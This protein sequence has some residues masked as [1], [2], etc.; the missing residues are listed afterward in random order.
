MSKVTAKAS[1]RQPEITPQQAETAAKFRELSAELGRLP[2]TRELAEAL[3]VII[4]TAAARRKTLERKG[5]IAPSPTPLTERQRQTLLVIQQVEREQGRRAKPREIEERLEAMGLEARNVG[6]MRAL[7]EGKGLLRRRWN[8]CVPCGHLRAGMQAAAQEKKPE[9]PWMEHVQQALDAC[10]TCSGP[11]V[12]LGASAQR[13]K[14]CPDCDFEFGLHTCAR[15]DKDEKPVAPIGSYQ[16][17]K[18]AKR[19]RKAGL[20]TM[21]RGGGIAESQTHCNAGRAVA[22]GQK[23]PP[24]AAT[25]ERA[26]PMG[27][28]CEIS[29]CA[30]AVQTELTKFYLSPPPCP[31]CAGPTSPTFSVR[32]QGTGVRG[33][34]LDGPV[35]RLLWCDYCQRWLRSSPL[36]RRA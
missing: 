35:K 30:A 24:N 8:W 13:P 20:E 32:P 14:H 5:V 10:R 29:P 2:T 4:S 25:C 1:P 33:L 26:G 17:A 19:N 27:P 15:A 28:T 3:G 6:H 36:G 18:P 23:T 34:Q 22:F 11:S 9:A 12:H 21:S 7:L 16:S 31:V